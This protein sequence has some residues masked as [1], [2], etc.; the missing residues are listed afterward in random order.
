[1]NK[2]GRSDNT[3]S[4]A[5]TIMDVY[6]TASPD[7]VSLYKVVPA[8]MATKE[9]GATPKTDRQYTNKLAQTIYEYTCRFSKHGSMQRRHTVNRRS[10]R[11]LLVI[12]VMA[13]YTRDLLDFNL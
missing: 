7:E 5:R 13:C 9:G 6:E 3:A 11:I 10:V 2:T 8:C 12:Y 1:M 4:K